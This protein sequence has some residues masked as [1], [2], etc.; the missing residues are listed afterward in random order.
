MM[1]YVWR[2]QCCGR[3]IVMPK[4]LK[5]AYVCPICKWKEGTA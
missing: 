2:C 3:L 1:P 5:D 4:P